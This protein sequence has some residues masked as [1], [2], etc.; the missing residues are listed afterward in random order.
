MPQKKVAPVAATQKL[1]EEMLPVVDTAI[2]AELSKKK[3]AFRIRPIVTA[4]MQST[5]SK[6]FSGSTY[7]ELERAVANR[8]KELGY[9]VN[10]GV[11]KKS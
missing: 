9:I 7:N 6:L 4:L 5:N 2:N 11:V 3:G 10:K 1:S 8:V